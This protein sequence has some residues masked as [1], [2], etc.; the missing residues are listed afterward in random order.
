[1]KRII[2]LTVLIFVF[3]CAP[4]DRHQLENKKRQVE[5]FYKP[6]A[7]SQKTLKMIEQVLENYADSLVIKKYGILDPASMPVIKKYG[8]PET[9]FPF[10]LILDGS[11]SAE[12]DGKKIDFVEFPL[13]MK[14]IGRHEGNWSIPH[15]KQVLIHP[16]L[17]K[18]LNKSKDWGE[19]SDKE[20]EHSP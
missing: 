8:L 17:M 6:F 9:H 18:S 7:P 15:L 20:D 3:G 19:H 2:I 4:G 13:E 10:A 14:G 16:E 11:F 12:I 5:I 1:M